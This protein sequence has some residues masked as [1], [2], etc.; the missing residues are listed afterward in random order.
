MIA[1][2]TKQIVINFLQRDFGFTETEARQ[3]IEVLYLTNTIPCVRGYY[4]TVRRIGLKAINRSI[5]NSI[6]DSF[7]N[8]QNHS[9]FAV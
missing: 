2:T 4:L 3:E 8:A 5:R 6:Y 7:E 9:T 1:H